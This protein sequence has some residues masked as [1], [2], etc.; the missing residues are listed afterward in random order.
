[1]PLVEMSPTAFDDLLGPERSAAFA[2]SLERRRTAQ[3]ENTLWHVNSTG[4]GGGVAE[5]LQST[6]GYLL[7]AGIRCRWLVIDG[8][9]EFFVVT[10]R[11]HHLLHGKPGDG[12]GLDERSREAYERALAP[13]V[14]NI[15]R[16]VS[17][18]DVVIL[19]DPQTLGLAPVLQRIGATIIFT[20]HV[21][22]DAA[23]EHTRAAWQFLSPYV[24]ATHRQVFSRA[25]Y[26]WDGLDSD[27]VV[28]IPPCLDAFSAKNQDLD[29]DTVA[30]ILSAAGVV[31]NGAGPQP[32]FA[33]R[34]GTTDKVSLRA[35]MT[36][37]DA[38]PHGVPIVTQ[39]SRW[40]PLKDHGGVMA[41]FVQ[42]VAP[43]SDAH[44]VLA[45]PSPEGVTDDPEGAEVFAQL[46][47]QWSNLPPDLQARV[48]L[49]SLPMDDIEQNAA[50]VNALQRHSTVVVQKSLA[51]G[52][53][54]TVAEAMWKGRPTV[55]S[56]VGGI[57]D[58]IE[59]GRSGLLVD[60]A[61]DVDEFGRM[62]SGLV[63][64]AGE[65]TRLG[66]AARERV[67]E[68]YLAP[69]HLGAYLDLAGA[70]SGG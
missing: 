5:M 64:D 40:D 9:P 24:A 21:G 59:H 7:G 30:A 11:I 58:Q 8:D 22:V 26:A 31:P 3:H 61:T 19:N 13:D 37:T 53:G 27:Q 6:L 49:A 57:Q 50:I 56:R 41:G 12:Q 32:T 65:Q 29:D 15:Q 43:E 14:D 4:Q 48:H 69:D 60:D 1:M 55:G 17:R 46:R 16:I 44:L 38:V 62:L 45:G 2:A 25:Q 66:A 54:L 23:N 33:R 18:G 36:E 34:D 28:V 35:A 70:I 67:C 42:H 47:E 63:T 39:V 20:C 10:K 68:R 52:F 51:E